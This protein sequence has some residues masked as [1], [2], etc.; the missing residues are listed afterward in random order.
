MLATVSLSSPMRAGGR[1]GRDFPV[2]ARRFLLENATDDR[3][4][5]VVAAVDIG[6]LNQGVDDPLR[7]CAREEQ[8]LDSTV[9]D[10]PRQSIAGKQKRIAYFGVSVEHVWLDLVRHPD[11]ACDDVAL[12]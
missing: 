8:L 11:A 6:F 2:G 1:N 9:F 3:F 7:F 5:V 10:H 4:D 12:G